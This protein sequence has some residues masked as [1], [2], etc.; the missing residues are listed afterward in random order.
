[1]CYRE[2]ELMERIERRKKLKLANQHIGIVEINCPYS[3]N[4]PYIAK[5][6]GKEYAN[7][8]KIICEQI[9]SF[10]EKYRD[11]YDIND[12]GMVY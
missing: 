11:I 9:K 7:D 10:R 3:F 12:D 1:M 8:L 2:M 5:T 6:F 4:F